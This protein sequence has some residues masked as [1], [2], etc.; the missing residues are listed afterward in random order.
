MIEHQ[1]VKLN[2]T[3]KQLNELAFKVVLQF[4]KT[5]GKEVNQAFKLSEVG[6]KLTEN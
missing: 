2:P 3:N 4:F 5:L 6:V 1:G